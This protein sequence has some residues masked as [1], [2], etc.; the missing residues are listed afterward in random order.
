MIV[1][2]H[3]KCETWKKQSAFGNQDIHCFMQIFLYF[4]GGP[5]HV[6]E[7]SQADSKGFFKPKTARINFAVPSVNTLEQFKIADVEMPNRMPAGIIQP[8]LDS[9]ADAP[10]KLN[11]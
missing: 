4:M 7:L 8:V 2:I 6:G 10:K 1:T 9:I 3:L 5:K 11:V